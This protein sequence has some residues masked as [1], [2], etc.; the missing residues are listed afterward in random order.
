MYMT[1]WLSC[2]VLISRPNRP[3]TNPIIYSS[4]LYLVENH[5]THITW[6][7]LCIAYLS[8][9]PS[10]RSITSVAGRVIV[11]WWYVMTNENYF[12]SL[13]LLT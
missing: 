13:V 12:Y 8:S 2:A 10:S 11:Q 4:S 5:V 3:E 1:Q 9:I 6:L 7:S